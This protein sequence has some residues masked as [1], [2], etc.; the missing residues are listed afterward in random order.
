MPVKLIVITLGRIWSWSLNTGGLLIEVVL[1]QVWLYYFV[2]NKIS[3]K[4]KK[5]NNKNNSSN[6]NNNYYCFYLI[7]PLCLYL[8]PIHPLPILLLILELLQ[9]ALLLLR[10]ASFTSSPALLYFTTTTTTT[11]TTANGCYCCYYYSCR[12]SKQRFFNLLYV[13]P[14]LSYVRDVKFKH[15]MVPTVSRNFC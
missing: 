5:N 6:N 14:G 4:K 13:L 7:Q 2:Y 1:G 8:I 9:L 11:T 12:Y 3:K 10:L 15:I